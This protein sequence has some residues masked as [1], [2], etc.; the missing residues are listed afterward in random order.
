MAGLSLPPYQH[1][2]VTAGDVTI[3]V[4]EVPGE[5][6]P[7]LL[8]HGIGMDWRVWQ[9]VSRRLYPYFH[10]FAMDL[11]GHGRSSKP[12]SGYS[13]AHYAADVEDVMDSL[14]IEDGILVGS[15]LGGMV[16]AVVEAPADLI[17]FRVLVDPPIT[18]GPIRDAATFQ[19]ILRLKHRPPEELERFLRDRNPGAGRYLLRSMSEM[20]HEAADPV[21]TEM[22][23]DPAGYF[24][25]DQA[26][27]AIES[28]T[29]LLQADPAMGPALTTEGAERALRLLPH[30]ELVTVMGAGHAVHAFRPREFAEL[31]VDFTAEDGTTRPGRA[32]V[33]Q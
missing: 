24:D 31:I 11:R 1:R 3:H 15:S 4:A 9:A 6:R 33:L 12:E 7:M 25:V 8:L 32:R 27:R 18:G 23:A 5:G 2:L 29:L 30:G 14:E 19:Q 20:W 13:L 28:P 21:I 26:L 22:L 17:A 10:L 16:A